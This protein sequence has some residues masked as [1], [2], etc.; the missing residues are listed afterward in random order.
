MKYEVQ[1]YTLCDGW[2]NT[3]TDGTTGEPLVFSSYKEAKQELKAFLA[4]TVEAVRQGH[5]ARPCCRDEFRIA[6]V[7]A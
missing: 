5:M 7:M 1:T 3:W 4:D 2:T 6:E